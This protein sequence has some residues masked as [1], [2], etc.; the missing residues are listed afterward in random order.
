MA[1]FSLVLIWAGLGL[2]VGTLALAACFK[3]ASW[4]R[5]GRLQF[6]ALSLGSALLGGLLGWAIFGRLFSPAT[7]LWLAVLAVWLP[8]LYAGARQRL[9]R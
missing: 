4:G 7:A 5:Y 1:T 6:L 8:G 3:P 2:L 9:A